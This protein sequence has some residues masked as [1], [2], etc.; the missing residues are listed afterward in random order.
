MLYY[1]TAID[2]I[3]RRCGIKIF[4]FGVCLYISTIKTFSWQIFNENTCLI[5]QA[6]LFYHLQN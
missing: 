5:L 3:H 6:N 2:L 4:V 1:N